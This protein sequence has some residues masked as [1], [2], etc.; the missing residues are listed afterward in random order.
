MKEQTW[1]VTASLPLWARTQ[2]SLFG[3]HS[4]RSLLHLSWISAWWASLIWV[5]VSM[6]IFSC[7]QAMTARFRHSIFSLEFWVNHYQNLKRERSY[8]EGME[9]R[10][11][12]TISRMQAQRLNKKAAWLSLHKM[13]SSNKFWNKSKK[14]P[15]TQKQAKRRSNQKS[16][17][18]S[19]I[20]MLL[21]THI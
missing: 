7:H 9:T 10:C 12:K 2:R 8:P 19:T 13:L 17:E 5:G 16:N 11:Y 6:E 15:S 20:Q 14:R 21:W 3:N 18:S 4:W 1:I